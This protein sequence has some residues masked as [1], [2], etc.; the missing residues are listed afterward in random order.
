MQIANIINF[1]LITTA[2]H[3]KIIFF[4]KTLFQGGYSLHQGGGVPEVFQREKKTILITD[5][6]DIQLL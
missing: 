6:L 5:G 1:A 3:A 2:N 4:L